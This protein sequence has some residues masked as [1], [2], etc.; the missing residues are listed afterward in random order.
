M[1]FLLVVFLSFYFNCCLSET[2]YSFAASPKHPYGLPNTNAPE[3]IRDFEQLVGKHK[4]LSQSRKADQ[5]WASPINM[6]WE[7][8]YI[9]NGMAV[10]DL[11]LK[12]D[13]RHS[14][15][16]RL[17]DK[18][19]HQ[20]QVHY[21][22]SVNSSKSK[23][24]PMWTGGKKE[25]KLVF[26]RDQ[27]SPSGQAGF[28]RLSFFNITLEGFKWVGEWVNK[29]GGNSYPTWKIGCKKLSS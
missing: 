28:F 1:K 4:C 27:K 12:E 6:T 19:K 29:T 23:N 17:Y 24:L 16:I 21:F 20:W 22:S 9:M 14:G 8:K 10:Q 7:F 25:G 15:S 3:Q 5:K 11:T 26:Y 18:E 13:G 2:L